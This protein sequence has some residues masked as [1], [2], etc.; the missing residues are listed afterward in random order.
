[1]LE[2]T[3]DYTIDKEEFF[4]I[5]KSNQLENR[6]SKYNPIVALS[7]NIFSAQDGDI[8]LAY[9]DIINIFDCE[10]DINIVRLKVDDIKDGLQFIVDTKKIDKYKSC[11]FHFFLNSDFMMI[12]LSEAMEL[13]YE[14]ANKEA[15][16]ALCISSDENR[17]INEIGINYFYS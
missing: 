14:S 10:T 11:C 2:V 1:M 15:N 9:N 12:A 8:N 5:L 7:Q 6:V 16:I 4:D 17:S 3:N 13:I